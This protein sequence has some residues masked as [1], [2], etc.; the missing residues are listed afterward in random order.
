MAEIYAEIRGKGIPV[1]LIHGFCETS[2]IWEPLVNKLALT[3]RVIT[4]DLPGFGKSTLPDTPFGIDDIAGQVHRY[5]DKNDLLNSI[6]IGHSLGG[7]IILAMMEHHYKDYLGYG[8]FHSTA[9]A[10]D[11]EKRNSRN[12]TIEF[13]NK[14]GVN[15]FAESFVPQLFHIGNR[16]KLAAVIKKVTSVAAA[17]DHRALVRY[18]EAMRDRPDRSALLGLAMPVLFIAGEQDGSVPI[19]K[20]EAQ[21][22]LISH[23]Y[24]EVLKNVAHMGMYEA[25]ERSYWAIS[26]FLAVFEKPSGTA[27]YGALPDSDLKKNL[28]CG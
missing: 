5:L 1:V 14:R 19:A 3:H 11:E 23:P 12:K 16:P 18:M 25:T 26:R 20:S 6:L 13:V 10:D 4:P 17:T 22:P 2:S 9:L 24:I 27:T 21:F 7:Y 8:L 28:G 15:V